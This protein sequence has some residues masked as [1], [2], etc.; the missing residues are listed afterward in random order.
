M[1]LDCETAMPR[2][3]ESAFHI[4]I[5]VYAPWPPAGLGVSI[6]LGH[7]AWDDS[8]RAKSEESCGRCSG[9][10]RQILCAFGQIRCR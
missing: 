3:R 8:L 2:R 7:D 6:P 1:H 5:D 4:S 9:Q 10:L